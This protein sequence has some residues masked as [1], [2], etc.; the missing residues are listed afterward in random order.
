MFNLSNFLKQSKSTKKTED[1]DF[2]VSKVKNWYEERY[3]TIIVHRN[4]LFILLIIFLILSIVSILTVAIVIN[5]K[6]F[7]PFVIQVDET[8][9][10]AKIVNPMS[11]DVLEA[12]DSLARYFIKKYIIARETYNPVDFDTGARQ[13][14]RLFSTSGIFWNYLSYIKNDAVNPTI[15]YGQKNTTYLTVKSWS[16]LDKKKYLV[17][18]SVHETEGSANVY[19]KIAIVDY[20]YI[21]MNLTD[22][23]RDINPIGFQVKGYRVDE[24]NS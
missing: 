22:A 3:D 12:D 14:V 10:M 9:G 2:G 19:N 5:S 20:D 18:F 16:K 24:D 15:V 1:N 4:I 17:R 6:R 8:T 23:E 7:D 13:I 11:S 21:A